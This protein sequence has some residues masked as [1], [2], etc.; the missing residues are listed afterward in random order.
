[1]EHKKSLSLAHS[2]CIDYICLFCWKIYHDDGRGGG[3]L[4]ILDH[5]EGFFYCKNIN[6]PVSLSL[7]FKVLYYSVVLRLDKFFFLECILI[8]Q[9]W[10]PQFWFYL[11]F[12]YFFVVQW[13]AVSLHKE[14]Q[15]SC[16]RRS[17]LILPR[18]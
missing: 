17:Y 7:L 15:D 6:V 5:L 13:L 3:V 10:I 9:W 8:F 2:L 18:L 1:M 16:W 14:H 4:L 12:F 11:S